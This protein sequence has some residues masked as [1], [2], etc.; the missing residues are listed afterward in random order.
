MGCV[1]RLLNDLELNEQDLIGWRY[2]WCEV[3]A[4]EGEAR[5]VVLHSG[6][7]SHH[8]PCLTIVLL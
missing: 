3:F 4:H 1:Q 7:G 8:H 6:L 2:T 5:Q